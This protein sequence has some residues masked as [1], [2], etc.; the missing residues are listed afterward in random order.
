MCSNSKPQNQEQNPKNLI[1]QILKRILCSTVEVPKSFQLLHRITKA[2]ND[3][4]KSNL[5][6]GHN[7]TIIHSSFTVFVVERTDQAE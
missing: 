3:R 5:R 1:R 6:W 4:I 7:L 2:L